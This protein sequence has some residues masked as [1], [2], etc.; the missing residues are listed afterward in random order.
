MKSDSHHDL[1]DTQ[2]ISKREIEAAKAEAASARAAA[3]AAV[4]ILTPIL[5]R[6]ERKLDSVLLK[7]EDIENAEAN[8]RQGLE[9]VTARCQARCENWIPPTELADP[10]GC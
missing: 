4:E 2:P 6:F 8:L 1:S 5:E 3:H 7:M 9:L 10:P